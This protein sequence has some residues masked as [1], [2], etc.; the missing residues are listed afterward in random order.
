MTFYYGRVWVKGGM[1]AETGD[2]LNTFIDESISK[3]C[4][5]CC[6]LFYNKSN[7]NYR[8]WTCNRCHK[9]LLN[10]VFEP[11][12]ICIIWWNN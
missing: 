8:E 12:Y 11:R 2:Y 7:F 10:T 6:L 4:Y 9:I 1:D 3:K 5:G